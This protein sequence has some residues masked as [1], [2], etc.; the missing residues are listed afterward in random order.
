MPEQ[1]R[2]GTRGRR[3][4][5]SV[6]RALQATARDSLSAKQ[7]RDEMFGRKASG[8][9]REIAQIEWKVH[10]HAGGAQLRDKVADD[11]KSL[12]FGAYAARDHRVL[13]IPGAAPRQRPA[14]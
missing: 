6:H 3:Y 4:T 5:T 10:A 7:L 14:P 9:W 1:R 13:A 2:L 12:R 11:A 8:F